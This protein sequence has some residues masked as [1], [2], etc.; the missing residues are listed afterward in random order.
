[1]TRTVPRADAVPRPP[2]APEPSARVAALTD[3]A[4]CALLVPLA[5]TR[6]PVEHDALPWCDSCVVP[7]A[8][9]RV[10][11]VTVAVP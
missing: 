7:V 8:V 9:A 6:V 1:M 4:P 2:F 10:R 11:S 3:A 5:T